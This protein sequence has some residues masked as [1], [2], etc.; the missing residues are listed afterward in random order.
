MYARTIKAELLGDAQVDFSFDEKL[1][2]KDGPDNETPQQRAQRWQDNDDRLAQLKSDGVYDG[3]FA[4]WRKFN[5]LHGWMEDL[6]RSKGG[7]SEDFNC[8]NVRL[9]L[10]D[11]Q[12]LEEDARNLEPRAGF[13]FG[14]CD[15][16]TPEDVEDVLSF[17]AKAREAI[18]NGRAVVY[19]SWW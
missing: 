14:S 12:A 6:Y 3:D 17:V 15:R 1:G 10:E 19:S 5:N 9:T 2:L 18:T 8:D 7:T 11:L 16:M 4:Y 13:F